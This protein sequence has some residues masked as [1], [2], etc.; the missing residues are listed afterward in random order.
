MAITLGF[1][2]S[3]TDLAV[4][5]TS[6][7]TYDVTTTT[8]KLLVS[9]YILVE[10][11]GDIVWENELNG[12][13]PQYISNCPTGLIPIAATKILTSGTV[14]G[15]LRTTNATTGDSITWFADISY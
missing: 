1:T 8:S 4:I 15:I 11:A 2:A 5:D 6:F 10:V 13:G 7:G 12:N 9:S 14:G 3:R